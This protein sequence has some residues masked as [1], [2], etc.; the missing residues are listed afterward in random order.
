MENNTKKLYQTKKKVT[1][2]KQQQILF[3]YQVILTIVFERRVYK[4][5]YL[6]IYFLSPWAAK[7]LITIVIYPEGFLSRGDWG[8]GNGNKNNNIWL[9]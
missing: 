5:F 1:K 9:K 6:F 2:N 8:Q 4:N 3:A 7:Q